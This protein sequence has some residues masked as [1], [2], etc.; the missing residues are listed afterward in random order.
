MDHYKLHQSDQLNCSQINYRLENKP[1][2]RKTYMSLHI[3]AIRVAARITVKIA[4]MHKV[5]IMTTT[6]K[7]ITTTTLRITS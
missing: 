1:K 3:T 7:T 4:D 2:K 6:T 5:T